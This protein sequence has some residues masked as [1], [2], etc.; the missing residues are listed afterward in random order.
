MDWPGIEHGLMVRGH[1]LTSWS[2]V[3]PSQFMGFLYFWKPK[4]HLQN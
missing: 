2:M 3:L 1:Q 4:F